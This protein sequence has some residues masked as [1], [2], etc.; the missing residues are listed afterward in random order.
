[1]Y[2]AVVVLCRE[3]GG[4]GIG[5]RIAGRLSLVIGKPEEREGDSS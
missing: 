2:G 5:G 3:K 4:V 1:M